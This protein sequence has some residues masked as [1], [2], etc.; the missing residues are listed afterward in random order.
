MQAW[1]TIQSLLVELDGDKADCFAQ[2]PAYITR[3]K[4]ADKRNYAQL[5]LSERG[6][7]EAAFFCPASCRQAAS[8]LR[9][10][11][12]VDGTHTRSKYRMQLIIACGIDANNN[13]VPLAW[14]LVPIEDEY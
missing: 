4:A 7:F 5:K 2:F 6:N 9:L 1:R 3:Y 14:A 13:G 12:A 8:Q 11:I 10:F